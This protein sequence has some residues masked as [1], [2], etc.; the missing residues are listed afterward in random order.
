[1]HACIRW[2]RA[3]EPSLPNALLLGLLPATRPLL[4]LPD[5]WPP[6]TRSISAAICGSFASSKDS[7][8]AASVAEAASPKGSREPGS[9]QRD[10]A[11]IK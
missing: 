5:S 6:R 11:T 3:R 7:L 4:P 9:A 2:K 8:S 1:M 10:R